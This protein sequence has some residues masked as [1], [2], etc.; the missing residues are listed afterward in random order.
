MISKA[1]PY[2]AGTNSCFLNQLPTLEVQTVAFEINPNAGGTSLC[3]R[4]KPM[5]VELT[6]RPVL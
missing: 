4:Y 6:L 5:L 2:A 1:N 3:W